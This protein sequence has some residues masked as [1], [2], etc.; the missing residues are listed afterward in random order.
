MTQI[1]STH[2]RR[3][4]TSGAWPA[5]GMLTGASK[6]SPVSMAWII[7]EGSSPDCQVCR[8]LVPASQASTSAM[9]PAW[10]SSRREIGLSSML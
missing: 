8:S 2:R 1:D 3:S 6:G 5:F 10:C 9:Y 4:G 7:G